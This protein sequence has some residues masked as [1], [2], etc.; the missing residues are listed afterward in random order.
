[1]ANV[2]YVEAVSVDTDHTTLIMDLQCTMYSFLY[3]AF[4]VLLPAF[5]LVS[6]FAIICQYREGLPILD[7]YMRF[8]R[9]QWTLCLVLF[10]F[11]APFLLIWWN[12][13]RDCED[14]LEPSL[15][16][17]GGALFC[18]MLALVTRKVLL[19]DIIAHYIELWSEEVEEEDGDEE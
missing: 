4:L 13:V 5:I 19:S 10:C 8:S 2:I 18:E 9:C 17:W 12:M 7:K 1:M 15:L 6:H 16:F 11:E 3:I 14:L